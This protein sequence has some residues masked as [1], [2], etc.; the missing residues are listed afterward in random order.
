MLENVKRLNCIALHF[1]VRLFNSKKT[2]RGKENVPNFQPVV[3]QPSLCATAHRAPL[4][5]LP[6][7]RGFTSFGRPLPRDWGASDA[8]ARR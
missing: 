6:T 8:V 1:G 5:H 3:C 7:S 2:W 4:A